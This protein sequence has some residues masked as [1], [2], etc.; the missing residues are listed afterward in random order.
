MMDRAEDMVDKVEDKEC[1]G[2]HHIGHFSL[3]HFSSLEH[4]VVC[5]CHYLFRDLFLMAD[6][7]E[8]PFWV[9]PC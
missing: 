4:H 6:Q 7:S 9:P 5:D 8:S 3:A 2:E 1:T